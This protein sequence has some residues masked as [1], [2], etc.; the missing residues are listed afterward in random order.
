MLWLFPGEEVRCHQATSSSRRV[1]CGEGSLWSDDDGLKTLKTQVKT[2]RL[3]ALRAVLPE[4]EVGGVVSNGRK[5]SVK[6]KKTLET[7]SV[8]GFSAGEVNW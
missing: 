3:P 4:I 5:T 6:I 1:C 2:R 8:A 7:R